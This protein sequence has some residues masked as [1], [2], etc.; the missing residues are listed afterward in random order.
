MERNINFVSS[1]LPRKCGIATFTSDLIK[2]VSN[3]AGDKLKLNVVAMTGPDALVY[4][5]IVSR[6]VSTH[7]KKDYIQAADHLNFRSGLGVTSILLTVLVEPKSLLAM[8]GT[9]TI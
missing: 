7:V 5:P 3:S 1:F 9:L 2:Y 8:S 4:Q 6:V